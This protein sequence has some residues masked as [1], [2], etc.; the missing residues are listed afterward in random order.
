MELYER[1]GK[2]VPEEAKERPD[3]EDEMED[4]V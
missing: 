2:K 1:L 3:V 4:E